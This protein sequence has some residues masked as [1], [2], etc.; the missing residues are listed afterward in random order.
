MLM[1]EIARI[2]YITFGAHVHDHLSQVENACKVGLPWV[3]LRIKNANYGDWIHIARRACEFCRAHGVALIINDNVRI[4]FDVGAHGVHLGRYDMTPIQARAILGREAIIGGTA[5]TLED[6][7]RLIQQGVDYIGLGPFRST[8]T[9]TKL[10]PVLGAEGI[11]R[12][13]QQ[14]TEENFV[15]PIVVIGGVEQGDL[16]DLAKLGAHGVA[17]SGALRGTGEAFRL[18]VE[19]FLQTLAEHF[20]G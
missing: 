19:E 4:A 9:K 3:Q 7:Q 5:N 10:S 16:K 11:Q 2:Q 6:V 8:K 1:P 13:W 15:P 14:L 12:I 20:H 18:Q 17:V